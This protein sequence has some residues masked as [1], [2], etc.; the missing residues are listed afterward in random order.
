[1][2]LDNYTK[3][4]SG[5]IREKIGYINYISDKLKNVID[6]VPSENKNTLLNEL[7]KLK[8]QREKLQE[9]MSEEFTLLI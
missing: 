1:M 6:L 7:D 5:N 3:M 4:K 8:Y 9:V 2:Y